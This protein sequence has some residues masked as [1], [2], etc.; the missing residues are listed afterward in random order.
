MSRP[1]FKRTLQLSKSEYRDLLD[2]LP[3]APGAGTPPEDGHPYRAI[4]LPLS[5][6]QPQGGHSYCL[7]FG[8]WISRTRICVLT[9]G[10]AETVLP[11]LEGN[12]VHEPD[13]VLRGLAEM[14]QD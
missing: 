1:T 8:R 5:L 10:D 3:S 6:E 7:V 13:L 12:W 11:L 4:D 14:A 9:G 2:R